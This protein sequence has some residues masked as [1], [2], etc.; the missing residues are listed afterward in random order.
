MNAFPRV[1]AGAIALTMWIAATGAAE[2]IQQT[3]R[4]LVGKYEGAVITVQIVVSQKMSYGGQSSSD[5]EAKI[6]TCGSVVS[7]DGLTI[8]PLDS[9]DPSGA[10]KKLMG[11]R[12]GEDFKM[13]SQVKDIRLVLDGG[14]EVAATAVLR[15]SDLNLAILKPIDKLDKPLPC[16]D[17]SQSAEPE[18]LDR[19]VALARL[20]K[21][22]DRAIGVMTGE[23]QAIVRK[24]RKLYIP[25]SEVVSGGY[26]VP[27]FNESGKVLGIV[28]M[29]M[30][31]GGGEHAMGSSSGPMIG[32]ILP[33]GDVRKMIAQAGS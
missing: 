28:V 8:I 25:S 20:G 7:P 18:M 30:L 32:A 14:K 24:P 21:V 10:F 12:M 11:S 1:C 4:E 27:V 15:D 6:E 26:G 13:D 23:I 31:P 29:R 16:I 9:L 5:E 17:L 33:T 2:S 19:V 3:G 22:A